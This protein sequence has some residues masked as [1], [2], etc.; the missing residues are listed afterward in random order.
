MPKLYR[1]HPCLSGHTLCPWQWQSCMLCVI[2]GHHRIVDHIVQKCLQHST[3]LLVY[4]S[5]DELNVANIR[6]MTDSR[7]CVALDVIMQHLAVLIGATL[8]EPL[9][10]IA[11]PIHL[12]GYIVLIFVIGSCLLANKGQCAHLQ[13]QKQL[14]S[15]YFVQSITI[16]S[17]LSLRRM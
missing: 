12:L 6:E 10:C 1:I 3:C 7:L 15:K 4:Q 9:L 16:Y 2:C 8:D 11:R 5:E 13:I 17:T 14:Y